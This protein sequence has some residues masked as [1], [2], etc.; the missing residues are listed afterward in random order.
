M[1]KSSLTPAVF[2]VLLALHGGPL[3]GYA[4]MKRARA[5][6]SSIVPMGP[7]TVYGTLDRLLQNGWIRE[8]AGTDSRRRVFE[9]L[10]VGRE[11]LE[12]EA[13]RVTRLARLVRDQG[14]FAGDR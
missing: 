1:K 5:S 2:H 14:I 6:A 8:L 13:A 9:L 10:P 3:H 12:D 11:A 4:I 7:G